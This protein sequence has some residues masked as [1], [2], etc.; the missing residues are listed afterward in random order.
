M[1]IA[2]YKRLG[3]LGG[4]GSAFL[5]LDRSKGQRL[6]AIKPLPHGERGRRELQ[7]YL[8]VQGHPHIV[9]FV[10]SFV[11]EEEGGVLYIVH[12]YE[13][14]GDLGRYLLACKWKQNQHRREREAER[15]IS[16][17]HSEDSSS[18]SSS[19]DSH[20]EE[21]IRN[22]TASGGTSRVWK[23]TE[24]HSLEKRGSSDGSPPAA[25]A[26]LDDNRSSSLLASPILPSFSS[27]MGSSL[28]PQ[29]SVLSTLSDISSPPPLASSS[30]RIRS[31]VRGPMFFRW[32][33][34]LLQAVEHCHHAQV[35][36]GGIHPE[37][38]YLSENGEDVCLGNFSSS[39][40]ATRSESVEGLTSGGEQEQKVE[41]KEEN[42][43]L[44]S[45]LPTTTAS[46]AHGN[47]F[48]F[49][50][51][52]LVSPEVC[53][54][55]PYTFETD[56]WGVGCVLYALATLQVPSFH[57]SS[58]S[59]ACA[60]HPAPGKEEEKLLS[61][62]AEQPAHG[63][64]SHRTLQE[65]GKEEKMF[66]HTGLVIPLPSTASPLVQK[67]VYT[68]LQENPSRRWTAH[69]AVLHVQRMLKEMH[70]KENKAPPRTD[71]KEEIEAEPSSS[72]APETIEPSEQH[73]VER[74][75]RSSSISSSSTASTNSTTPSSSSPPRTSITAA[76]PSAT[77][78]TSRPSEKEEGGGEVNTTVFPFLSFYTPPA[79]SSEASGWNSMSS[80]SVSRH[81]SEPPTSR[82]THTTEKGGE[83]WKVPQGPVKRPKRIN[84]NVPLALTTLPYP[85]TKAVFLRGVHVQ[86]KS[87]QEEREQR[88]EWRKRMQV[89]P[90]KS[91]W[92]SSHTGMLPF[93]S[94]SG[95][96]SSPPSS[97]SYSDEPSR[98]S[99]GQSQYSMLPLSPSSQSPLTR[100]TTTIASSFSSSAFGSPWEVVAS[101]SLN[102]E[103]SSGFAR[104][105]RTRPPPIWIRQSAT[106]PLSPANT[107]RSTTSRSRVARPLHRITT[108][109]STSISPMKLATPRRHDRGLPSPRPPHRPTTMAYHTS[110]RPPP[111]A[112]GSP[113]RKGREARD[114]SPGVSPT[115][116]G[117]SRQ[118]IPISTMERSGRKGGQAPPVREKKHVHFP[119]S[120]GRRTPQRSEGKG[121]EKR[122]R[123]TTPRHSPRAEKKNTSHERE[124]R[125]NPKRRHPKHERDM[126]T[127]SL[128][129]LRSSSS[130]AGKGKRA[131]PRPNP[132]FSSFR[133]RSPHTTAIPSEVP[134]TMTT[135]VSFLL[136]STSSL[137]TP[138]V[139]RSKGMG[140]G[141][142]RANTLPPGPPGLTST[143]TV[144]PVLPTTSASSPSRAPAHGW[145]DSREIVHYAPPSLSSPRH[146][147][148]RAPEALVPMPLLGPST[149]PAEGQQEDAISSPSAS[150]SILGGAPPSLAT[151]SS[152]SR[153]PLVIPRPPG[154]RPAPETS[155]SKSVPSTDP[156][157]GTTPSLMS[158]AM[159][160]VN[161]EDEVDGDG[162]A[163]TVVEDKTSSRVGG[164]TT[165]PPRSRTPVHR[166]GNRMLAPLTAPPPPPPLPSTQPRHSSSSSSMITIPLPPTPTL[167]RLS[168]GEKGVP[169]TI[170]P[171]PSELSTP[172]PPSPVKAKKGEARLRPLHIKRKAKHK[173]RPS[174]GR[175][176]PLVPLT[177]TSSSSRTSPSTSPTA[178]V[179][180]EWSK[181][182]FDELC[183]LQ[184]VLHQLDPTKKEEKPPILTSSAPSTSP[185]TPSQPP[186][187]LSSPPPQKEGARTAR[188][189]ET[190][191]EKETEPVKS[192][193]PLLTLKPST[194]TSSGSSVLAA[195]TRKKTLEHRMTSGAP[196]SLPTSGR[197]KPQDT[198][199]RTQK[200]RRRVDPTVHHPLPRSG[201]A[202]TSGKE[203]VEKAHRMPISTSPSKGKPKGKQG[204]AVVGTH[205]HPHEVEMISL[206]S[207]TTRRTA[208][209]AF[210]FSA[211]SSVPVPISLHRRLESTANPPPPPLLLPTTFPL[212]P[213]LLSSSSS[214]LG[215]G[216]LTGSTTELEKEERSQ[217]TRA[218]GKKGEKKPPAR[219][220]EPVKKKKTTKW[221]LASLSSLLPS[222]PTPAHSPPTAPVLPFITPVS[223][224]TDEAWNTIPVR[225]QRSETPSRV[226]PTSSDP[227][228][229]SPSRSLG[230]PPRNTASEAR[231]TPR[232]ASPSPSSS[233]SSSPVS[234]SLHPLPA[235]RDPFQPYPGPLI[236]T[237][238]YQHLENLK[239]VQQANRQRFRMEEEEGKR[240]PEG[241]IGGE[242]G[243]GSEGWPMA[244]PQGRVFRK[245]A[246][247]DS[248]NSKRSDS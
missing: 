51:A 200:G 47:S 206:T 113:S 199:G 227:R 44:S 11:E 33:L 77:C 186:S 46:S 232:E 37:N 69:D 196:P 110:R 170:L 215:S 53:K 2:H 208:P 187:R 128:S 58:S 70:S 132:G 4:R 151:L 167:H 226:S 163:E 237:P 147:R 202:T 140:I 38:I 79:S 185:S 129:P 95:F 84:P 192:H 114:R 220:E 35:M 90:K 89:S 139:A 48:S 14:G 24:E 50:F 228:T 219:G 62:S 224:N 193:P 162:G 125:K 49:C 28:G 52:S 3:T 34:Q 247:E 107:P 68:L 27:P 15:P 229:P 124:R 81:S 203:G 39:K 171:V 205:I 213:Q 64:I 41:E 25:L 100:T 240:L 212:P 42:A 5:A 169:S 31:R 148:W 136:S 143:P 223:Q 157:S 29:G 99:V 86:Q 112:V 127:V 57:F 105:E 217:G 59:S 142:P 231:S 222:S 20:W 137:S 8:C 73:S 138:V 117:R 177:S 221:S 72:P 233:S 67:I 175:P 123:G 197:R 97:F 191:L 54:G 55:D 94:F 243:S 209:T 96:S 18:S 168:S 174:P 74:E 134:E 45:S 246:R 236:P 184:A 190:T 121:H 176:P 173:K 131:L 36:H 118:Q 80:S 135:P 6:V 245:P 104:K 63:D 146:A 218:E 195:M 85:A 93:P 102:H 194:M 19:S 155:A 204:V 216:S 238:M 144:I 88:R 239:A 181:E 234:L 21:E 165:S 66:S 10:E 12:K 23:N 235:R 145:G 189:S 126:K 154:Q 92:N 159:S 133:R 91:G 182:R 178:P 111:L 120:A 188:M 201:T 13:R 65:V 101:R 244:R 16:S 78:A 119:K 130:P 26:G 207:D 7:L 98:A 32:T 87:K 108:P 141:G 166:Y 161:E 75:R 152:S 225:T 230:S 22:G 30:F 61:T 160:S 241:L 150:S 180:R 179:A 103:G 17:S 106:A 71:R 158:S 83:V 9:S 60:T 164:D 172:S 76:T 122:K 242:E 156:G 248:S 149:T 115:R 56:M 183:S 40:R 153:P 116:S 1:G 82:G 211:S 210:S 214:S 43:H 109:S 198:S